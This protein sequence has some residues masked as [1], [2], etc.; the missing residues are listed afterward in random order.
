MVKIYTLSGQLTDMVFIK[1]KQFWQRVYKKIYIL[2][3][4]GT[5]R[6]GVDTALALT[7]PCCSMLMLPN[8]GMSTA[9]KGLLMLVDFTFQCRRFLVFSRVNFYYLN[10]LLLNLNLFIKL[11]C[12][13]NDRIKNEPCK[14]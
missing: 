3:G 9:C 14:K 2:V 12:I 7:A 1:F 11:N 13:K 6:A 5:F 8:L 4:A 10:N